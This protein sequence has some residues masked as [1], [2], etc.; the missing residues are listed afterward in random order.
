MSTNFYKRFL[1][2]KDDFYDDPQLVYNEAK[3]AKYHEPKNYTGFRSL[4]VYHEAG[5]KQKL[6]RILG[7][8]ISRWDTDPKDE[9]GVFYFGYAKGKHKEIPGVHSDYPHDDITALVYLTPGLPFDCGTSLWMHKKT[10][11]MDPPT[12]ADA[13]QLKMKVNDIRNIFEED[14]KKRNKWLEIDR[15]G[16]RF[17]RLVAYP[18]GA[19]H[20]ATRHYGSAIKNVR[21]YQTFRIGVDWKTFR[22][23]TI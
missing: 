23:N 7:I 1:I 14:S 11:L 13:R 6:E 2:V 12:P 9:N 10:K 4:N 19:L 21:L 22:M 17:N 18:S 15:A 5:V 20:S 8:K 3:N 16:Y